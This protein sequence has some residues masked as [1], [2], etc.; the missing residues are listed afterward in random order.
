MKAVYVLYLFLFKT[1]FCACIHFGEVKIRLDSD[2]KEF[3]D[4]LID[5]DDVVWFLW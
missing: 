1:Y 5:N 2:Y 3:V 4:E